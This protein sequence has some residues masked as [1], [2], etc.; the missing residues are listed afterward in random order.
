MVICTLVSLGP[1]VGSR[2]DS[3]RMWHKDT[4]LWFESGIGWSCG[5]VSDYRAPCELSLFDSFVLS[6]RLNGCF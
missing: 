1:M 4:R 2:G 6:M 3:S 5:K